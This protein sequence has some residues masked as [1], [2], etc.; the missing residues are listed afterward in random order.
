MRSKRDKRGFTLIELMI[1]ILVIAVLATIVGLAIRNAGQRARDSRE[2]ANERTLTNAVIAFYN[3]WG[4][5]PAAFADLSAA[6]APA[7]A[8]GKSGTSGY[9]TWSPYVESSITTW[10]TGE[11]WS[12]GADGT[13]VTG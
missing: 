9:P 7:S 12:I 10:A 5:Y 2:T 1:V 8:G 4:A 11:G 3:D 13:I 6:A